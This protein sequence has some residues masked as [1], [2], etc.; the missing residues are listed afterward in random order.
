MTADAG[1]PGPENADTF[2]LRPF[3]EAPICQTSA[4]SVEADCN[5]L[6]DSAPGARE[7]SLSQSSPPRVSGT[8]VANCKSATMERL[9]IPH[10]NL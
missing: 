8:R 3:S 9:E 10:L 2:L 6:K 1:I 4:P 5:L 7:K